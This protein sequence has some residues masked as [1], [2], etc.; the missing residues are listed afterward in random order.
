MASP[1]CDKA[2]PCNVTTKL[3]FFSLPLYHKR[4]TLNVCYLLSHPNIVNNFDTSFL[5]ALPSRRAKSPTIWDLLV[6]HT[7]VVGSFGVHSIAPPCLNRV[8]PDR[9][10]LRVLKNKEDD[11]G[12]D[13]IAR[14][15]SRR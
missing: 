6:R 10:I 12:A 4:I 5:H 7:S 9:P 14:F 1:R 3:I 2:T 11:E 15:Q 8:E 13:G